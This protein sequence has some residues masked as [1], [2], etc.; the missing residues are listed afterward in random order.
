MKN[1]NSF[2]V[3]QQEDGRPLYAEL[4]DE[5]PH[6]LIAGKTGSGK[7]VFLQALIAALAYKNSPDELQF[8]LIDGVRRGFKPLMTLPQVIHDLISKNEDMVKA[9]KWFSAVIILRLN[10]SLIDSS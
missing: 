9:V 3:G 5:T 1:K 6:F 8:I 7:T 4:C 10:S 2:S